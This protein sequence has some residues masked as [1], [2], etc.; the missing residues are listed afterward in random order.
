MN[1]EEYTAMESLNI[2]PLRSLKFT[3]GGSKYYPKD[4]SGC[5]LSIGVY[6]VEKSGL[7]CEL[8]EEDLMLNRI[9]N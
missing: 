8:T 1:G 2:N 7:D 6:Y 5:L 9:Y 3:L 4:E